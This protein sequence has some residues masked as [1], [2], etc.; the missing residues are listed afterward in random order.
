MLL[1]NHAAQLLLS[2]I[3]H[4][5]VF[6]PEEILTGLSMTNLPWYLTGPST[7]VSVGD[8]VVKPRLLRAAERCANP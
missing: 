7:K 1:L 6:V 8:L 2:L 5:T 4:G 3:I